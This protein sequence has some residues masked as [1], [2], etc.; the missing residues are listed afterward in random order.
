MA[1]KSASWKSLA[2]NT[3]SPMRV[4]LLVSLLANVALGATLA[5]LNSRQYDVDAYNTALDHICNR[6]YDYVLQQTTDQNSIG[7]IKQAC[8]DTVLKTQ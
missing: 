2:F 4:V 6:D 8:G 3:L 5:I 7:A 1:R